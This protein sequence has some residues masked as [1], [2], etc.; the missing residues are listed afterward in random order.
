MVGD[1]T[2]GPTIQ[3]GSLPPHH[4]DNSEQLALV[5]GIISLCTGQL[6][7]VELY[8]SQTCTLVLIQNS[9]N[10]SRGRISLDDKVTGEI[11]QYQ[12]LATTHS[13]P[14]SI[15]ARLLGRSPEPMRILA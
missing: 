14:H 4:S 2:C 6:A 15:K 12:N 8:R 1:H 7:T 5:G 10:C 11:G 9:T 3:I 13:L